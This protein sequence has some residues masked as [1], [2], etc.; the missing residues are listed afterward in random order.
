ML[1]GAPTGS[2]GGSSG[3]L[4]V[5]GGGTGGDG[6]INPQTASY[7]LILSDAGRTIQMNV[8][9]A[10]NLT[11]PTNASVAFP[12]G[13]QIVV[14]QYGAGQTSFV[15]AGGVTID[16]VS[17][18]NLSSQFATAALLKIG[19]DEWVLAGSLL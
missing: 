13:T 3:V 2:G 19:T 17:T 5:A 18:L 14:I 8:A 9:S 11:V 4:S 15:A 7:T 16:K 12:I 1:K 10:N 6:S